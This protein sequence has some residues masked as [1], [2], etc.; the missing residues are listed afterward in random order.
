MYHWKTA[1]SCAF[2][3]LAAYGSHMIGICPSVIS[4]KIVQHLMKPTNT[5]QAVILIAQKQ[6]VD[7][8]QFE[9]I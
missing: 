7:F 6:Q 3:L 5:A 2:Q 9:E 8:V 4:T 1:N